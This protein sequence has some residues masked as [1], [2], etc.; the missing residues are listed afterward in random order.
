MKTS[1]LTRLRRFALLLMSPALLA[2]A[3]AAAQTLHV[4][5]PGGPATAMKECAA[6]FTKQT[7]LDVAVTAGPE[8]KW[9]AQAQQDADL[10]YGGA[11]YMLTQTA[12]AHPG[13]IDE[14]SRTSLYARESAVLV[15]PGNPLHIKRLED[16]AR[17]GVRL[18][19]VN[20]AGQM[21]M[22]E[23]M[24]RSSALISNLQHNTKTSV[25]TSA[26][27]VDLWQQKPQDYDAWITYA[28]WQPRLPGSALVR[29]P[30]DQR[31]SRGTPIALTQRTT[32]AAAARQ[33]VAFL[34]SADGHAIFR[35][36]GWE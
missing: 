1:P 12:L 7:G 13:F 36:N 28:S 26:E 22:T 14:A 29:L 3:P 23:D 9:L 20:G 16:L 24:A 18:L 32:Q 5:G 27:A 34:Q 6:A 31:V 8:P 35:R 19:D 33:F 10:V 21:G 2:A 25:K 30:R 15:R 17:P 11:E 4:Y